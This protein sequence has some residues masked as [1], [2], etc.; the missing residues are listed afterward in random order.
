M[1]TWDTR[2][3]SPTPLGVTWIGEEKAYNFALYS[4]YADSVRLLLYQKADPVSPVVTYWFDPLRNK[5]GRVWHTRIPKTKM[6]SIAY[7][8]YS[9]DGPADTGSRF[10]RHAFNPQKVLLA[11]I[12]VLKTQRQPSTDLQRQY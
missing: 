10:E 6:R 7:Y 9:I 8:A 2:E 4:K 5:T 1:I 3:G 11:R 12:S